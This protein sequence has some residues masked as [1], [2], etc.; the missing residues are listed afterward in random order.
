PARPEPDLLRQP[1]ELHRHPRL[2][3]G[4]DVYELVERPERLRQPDDDPAHVELAKAGQVRSL[5]VAKWLD[6]DPVVARRGKARQGAANVRGFEPGQVAAD[7][8]AHRRSPGRRP[9]ER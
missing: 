8:K 2:A 7:E 4:I 3:P 9:L 5:P 1:G 6:H